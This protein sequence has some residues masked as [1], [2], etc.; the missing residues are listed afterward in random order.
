MKTIK[1][2]QLA[3]IT[4]LLLGLTACNN[5]DDDSN[6][7]ELESNTVTNLEATQ[8]A[9]YS[10]NPP[11]ITGDY[12]KFSFVTGTTTTGNDWDIAFRGSTIIVNGGEATTEDQPERTGE[13]AAYITS[14]TLASVTEINTEL[15]VSD[16]ATD[17][18]AIPTGSDNG[19]YNYNATTHVISPIAG[20]I[21]VVKTI[22]GTYAKFEITSY[23]ENGAPNEALSNSQFYSF[24]YVY[25][26]NAGVT[27]F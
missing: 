23:Y 17:G 8:S 4:T 19:W 26:P 16:S 22:T 1:T 27:T 6:T 10:T 24:N 21:I 11:S 13:V 5:D 14:G 9:D 7:L 3:V 25:Q 12:I 2:I 15:L 20:K 18:L